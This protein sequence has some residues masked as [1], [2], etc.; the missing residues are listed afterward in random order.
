MHSLGKETCTTVVRGL[1]KAQ[2]LG[3]ARLCGRLASSEGW[4]GPELL[5]C[6]IKE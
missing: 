6:S 2:G 5:L 1:P 4:G 3:P